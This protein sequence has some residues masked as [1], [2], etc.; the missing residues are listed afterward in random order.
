MCDPLKGFQNLGLEAGFHRGQRQVGAFVL[1]LVL[2]A[3]DRI[4]VGI[5]FLALLTGFGRGG[6]VGQFLFL[7]FLVVERLAEG[8]FEV[9]DVAQQ[10]LLVQKLLAPHGDGLEGQRAFAQAR[11]HRVAAGLDPL[12]DGDLA[13]AGQQFDR[14]HFA[15]VHAHRVVGA[16]QL[17]GFR[18]RNRHLARGRSDH[19]DGP[20]LRLL[21]RI[22]VLDH[23]DAHFRQH[24]HHIL[25]LFGR[26]VFGGK[27]SVQLV[28]GDITAFA[29]IGDHAFDSRLAHVQRMGVV[30]L[31]GLVVI[32]VLGGH[33][34]LPS[35]GG[36]SRKRRITENLFHI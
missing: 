19:G 28:I 7:A 4:A 22:V 18:G 32:V 31:V 24:R 6:F 26:G 13:L 35:S 14:T 10:D 5:Q 3:Q 25:D 9:D 12:G 30:I 34:R 23:V 20:A 2:L 11:D 16:I 15:Q 36:D 8:G 17:F 21:G 1:V 27:G 29:R 33:Q